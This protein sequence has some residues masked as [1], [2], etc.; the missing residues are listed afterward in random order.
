MPTI[1]TSMVP[2]YHFDPLELCQTLY[3]PEV[4]LSGV[5]HSSSD[6]YIKQ[7]RDAI[8]I[9]KN[10]TAGK[11]AGI[12]HIITSVEIIK[13]ADQPMKVASKKMTGK[14]FTS[15]KSSVRS[16]SPRTTI[17]DDKCLESVSRRA[18]LSEAEDSDMMS[19]TSCV[20]MVSNKTTA[21]GATK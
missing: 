7:E 20:S 15:V 16:P 21:S 1:D 19:G 14:S 12:K 4:Q 3:L 17:T 5:D 18:T 10:T 9:D 8:D 2:A 6:G 11:G 13:G